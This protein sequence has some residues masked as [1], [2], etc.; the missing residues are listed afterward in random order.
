MKELKNYIKSI[1]SFNEI[2]IQDICKEFKTLILSKDKHLLRK[3]QNT[4]SYYFLNKGVIRIYFEKD[5]KQFTAWFAFENDFFADLASIKS[6]LPSKYNIQA[7]EECE[8]FYI[9]HK[10]MEKLYNQYP[11]FQKFGRLIWETAFVKVVNS[12]IEFQT[13]TA[14]E[15]YL[16]TLKNPHL[17]QQIPLQYLASYLGIT[18]TSLSR[19]RKEI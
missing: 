2:E 14:K 1:V 7:L 19:L 10:S 8:V 9:E 13:L 11:K 4:F 17:I 5:N 3:G 16:N 6:G 18:Q 12:I 15:R